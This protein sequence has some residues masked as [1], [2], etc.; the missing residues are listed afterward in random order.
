MARE[1][2]SVL[3]FGWKHHAVEHLLREYYLC[4]HVPVR[5]CVLCLHVLHLIYYLFENV[6][7]IIVCDMDMLM[8]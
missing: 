6:L 7:H 8:S 4:A 1:W 2:L 3:F 5:M